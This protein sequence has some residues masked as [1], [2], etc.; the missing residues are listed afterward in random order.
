MNKQRVYII[1]NVKIHRFSVIAF[2]GAGLDG[3]VANNT[4]YVKRIIGMPGDT[5]NY[6]KTGKLFINGKYVPQNFLVSTHSATHTASPATT[7]MDFGDFNLSKLARINNWVYAGKI[8][9]KNHYFVMGDNRNNSIDSR[10]FG[11]VPNSNVLGVVRVNPFEHDSSAVKY[12][13]S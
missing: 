5:I 9:P 13:N 10:F 6:T 8:V 7:N 3:D 1:K 4:Q 2:T 11:Y 12:I